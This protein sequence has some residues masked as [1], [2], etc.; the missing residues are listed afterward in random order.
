MLFALLYSFI[1]PLPASMTWSAGISF[2]AFID[3]TPF[4]WLF[5]PIW[6]VYRSL[7]WW[8]PGWAIL[9][10]LSPVQP[11]HILVRIFGFS[12]GNLQRLYAHVPCKCSLYWKFSNFFSQTANM[13][14]NALV[15][16]VLSKLV[17]TFV[18]SLKA[19]YISWLFSNILKFGLL[20]T[21][22]AY[23]TLCFDIFVSMT[24]FAFFA[25]ARYLID[26]YIFVWSLVVLLNRLLLHGP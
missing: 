11:L 17:R 25:F 1:Y 4:V 12:T 19:D 18:H 26:A 2:C 20:K 23:G 7:C 15:L 22:F 21:N 8:R 6:M 14:F 9:Q 10:P 13:R 24:M 3:T 16:P 5:L